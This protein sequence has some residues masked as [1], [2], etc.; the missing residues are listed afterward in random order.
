MLRKGLLT[1][2]GDALRAALQKRHKTKDQ[3]DITITAKNG[4]C[5]RPPALR[6]AKKQQYLS[7][8]LVINRCIVGNAS[9]PRHATIGKL[10]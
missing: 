5:S 6:V 4:K 7:D 10:C 1:S 8:L 9:T 2:L 3:A